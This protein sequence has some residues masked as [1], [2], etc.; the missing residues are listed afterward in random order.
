M[1]SICG[2]FSKFI[3]LPAPGSFCQGIDLAKNGFRIKEEVT[4]YVLEQNW[5]NPEDYRDTIEE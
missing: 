1:G 5:E 2:F 4:F 3:Y